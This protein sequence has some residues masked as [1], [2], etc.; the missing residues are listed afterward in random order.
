MSP[1]NRSDTMNEGLIPRLVLDV[2]LSHRLCVTFLPRLLEEWEYSV[3]PWQFREKTEL[4]Y[5]AH[6]LY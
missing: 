3:V 2:S 6:Y 4:N 5:I 1:K